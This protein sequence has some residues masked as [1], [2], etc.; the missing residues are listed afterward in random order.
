[1]TLT[2]RTLA[3][4]HSMPLLNQAFFWSPTC[5]YQWLC[6]QYLVL[7]SSF[8]MWNQKQLKQ[9]PALDTS[10]VPQFK[11]GSPDWVICNWQEWCVGV[12]AASIKFHSGLNNIFTSQ[13]L[14]GSFWLLFA[15]FGFL[16][17]FWLILDIIGYFWQHHDNLISCMLKTNMLAVVGSGWQLL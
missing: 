14:V 7:V 15:S 2:K 4:Q 16:S 1:M 17:F 8:T 5:P 6:S 3:C 12:T 10:L 9:R 11:S 13:F